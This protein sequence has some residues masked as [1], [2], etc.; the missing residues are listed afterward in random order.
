MD[1]EDLALEPGAEYD[2]YIKVNVR[3]PENIPLG[4]NI[5]IRNKATGQYLSTAHN[6]DF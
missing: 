6:G 5:Q 2:I 1:L 4:S 3:S